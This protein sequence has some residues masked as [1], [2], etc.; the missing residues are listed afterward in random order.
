MRDIERLS[1][2]DLRRLTDLASVQRLLSEAQEASVEIDGELNGLLDA[3]HAMQQ[4]L[5]AVDAT[6]PHLALVLGDVARLRTHVVATG[7]LAES[8]SAKVR[9][10]D[11]EQSRVQQCISE[12]E[13]IQELKVS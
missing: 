11:I 4:Q 2:D 6:R 9:Q 10:L 13:N 1:L 8:V 3:R 12:V 5:Q 7:Q